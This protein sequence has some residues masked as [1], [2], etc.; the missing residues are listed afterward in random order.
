MIKNQTRSYLKSSNLFSDAISIIDYNDFVIA[1]NSNNDEY[2]CRFVTNSEYQAYFNLLR[3]SRDVKSAIYEYRLNAGYLLFF[4]YEK[5]TE[6]KVKSKKIV[7]ILRNIFQESSFE[8]ALKKSHMSNVNNIYK[9][10][11]NRFAYLEMRIREIETQPKKDDI[12]WV[13]LSKYNII[14]DAKIFL[15]DLQSDIFKA[16]D[17]NLIVAYGLIYRNIDINLY[18][19][20]RL[21]PSFNLYY[22]P[23]G[24]MYCRCYLQLDEESIY[25]DIKKLDEFN[26]KY[27]CFMCLYILILNI[28]L[29]IILNSYS[30]AN[31]LLITKKIKKFILR[32]Q[33]LMK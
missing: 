7:D 8:I 10:L 30:I 11:D 23:I 21:L 22:A 18:N 25:E 24:M 32:Y 1:K 27:F 12:S 6:E 2:L 31:Y 9:V 14:L 5:M 29:E 26:K 20:Q 4:D 13:I 19:K 33:E 28:N 3:Y 16:I 17:S 15:Y